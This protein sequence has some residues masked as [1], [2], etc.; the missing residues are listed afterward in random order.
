M[1]FIDVYY[2]D[3]I[4]IFAHSPI[5]DLLISHTC[6]ITLFTLFILSFLILKPK[7]LYINIFLTFFTHFLLSVIFS[8]FYL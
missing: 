5:S 7:L 4:F 1:C 8:I 6:S 2:H 3:R